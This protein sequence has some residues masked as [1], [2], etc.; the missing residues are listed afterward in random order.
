MEIYKKRKNPNTYC[1]NFYTMNPHFH[2]IDLVAGCDTVE[3]LM[4]TIGYKI[5]DQYEF[6]FNFIKRSRAVDGEDASTISF[7]TNIPRY[8]LLRVCDE[9]INILSVVSIKHHDEKLHYAIVWFAQL[10][11]VV[12]YAK[13]ISY[14]LG[15]SD[16]EKM[17]TSLN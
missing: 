9:A 5:A 17:D 4:N 7:V 11:H 13:V 10:K 14:T 12:N 15:E 2:C 3:Q 6:I 1:F 16:V 8:K